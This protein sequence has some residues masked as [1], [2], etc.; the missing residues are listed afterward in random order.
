MTVNNDSLFGHFV[1]GRRRGY[2]NAWHPPVWAKVN[3]PLGQNR[4]RYVTTEHGL[5]EPEE[6]I[7]GTNVPDTVLQRIDETS[8][9]FEIKELVECKRVSKM[10]A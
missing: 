6:Q 8:P 1:T 3:I 5:P 2:R 9:P 10:V 4:F 7:F